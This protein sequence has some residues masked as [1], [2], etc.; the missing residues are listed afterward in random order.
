MLSVRLVRALPNQP[1]Q[2]GLSFVTATLERLRAPCVKGTM[3]QVRL[4]VSS[5]LPALWLVAAGHCLADP[6]SEHAARCHDT[7]VSAGK[8]AGSAPFTDACSLEQ[9]ARLSSRR[10]G[11]QAGG[12]GFLTP[13]LVATPEVRDREPVSVSSTVSADALGLAQC[14]QFYWRTALEPR[15]PSSDS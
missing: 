3:E 13:A 5:L 11:T 8:P 12:V 4:V 2:I 1:F 10:V 9:S 15:A 14:W 7:S 6:V